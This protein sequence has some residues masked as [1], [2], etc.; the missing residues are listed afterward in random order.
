MVAYHT[1]L[2]MRAYSGLQTQCL[3]SQCSPGFQDS[4]LVV[5]RVSRPMCDKIWGFA[6]GHVEQHSRTS[7]EEE[8]A[9]ASPVEVE[10][11]WIPLGGGSYCFFFLGEAANIDRS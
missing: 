6:E 8:D 9:R 4:Y 7:H 5:Q 1:W 11:G 3:C 10:A 2:C